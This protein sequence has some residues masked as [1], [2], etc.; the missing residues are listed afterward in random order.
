MNTANWMK[1]L[2]DTKWL[3]QIVMPGSHD[4]GVYGNTQTIIRASALVKAAYTVCQ[5]SD[6]G[7]QALAGS[8]FFD[9]RVFQRKIPRDERASP[10]QKH[11]NLLGHFAMEK[12]KGSDQ[13]TLGGYGG[14]LAAVLGDALDFVVSKPTEF[15]ILRFSH[16]YHPTECI[17]EI[18]QVV[19]MKPTWKSA[20]YTDTGNIATKPIG[21]LR[22]KVIMVFDEKFNHHI[23]PTEGIHRFKKYSDGLARIDGLATCGTFSSSMKMSDVHRGAVDAIA[24]HMEH[25]GNPDVGHLHFV[26]W[27]QTAGMLGEKDV[28]KTTTAAKGT[29]AWSG[30]AH[31]NLGDFTAELQQRAAGSAGRMPVNVISHDFVTADTCSKIIRLNPECV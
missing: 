13:P 6:F 27:Q 21:N 2:P 3:R 15:V 26:Y 12:V 4:A 30:G 22:G 8:R 17:D 11:Q 31:S 9:C 23:T 7:K 29:K 5:H 25:P 1:D 14:A 19:A 16:T 20:V 28:Y 24:K 10:D 18:K